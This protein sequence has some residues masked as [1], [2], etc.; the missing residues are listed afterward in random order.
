MLYKRIWTRNTENE[1]LIYWIILDLFSLGI[2]VVHFHYF[3]FKC[4]CTAKVIETLVIHYVFSL[5]IRG[6]LVIHYGF[7]NSGGICS[8]G[9][10]R[11]GLDWWYSTPYVYRFANTKRYTIICFIFHSPINITHTYLIT[12]EPLIFKLKT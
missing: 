11:Y 2:S 12:R 6:S 3:S 5:K 9:T 4:V 10:N 7:G 1:R 8:T